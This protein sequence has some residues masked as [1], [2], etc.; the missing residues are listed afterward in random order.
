MNPDGMVALLNYRVS[1]INT[2][3]ERSLNDVCTC[4][5]MVL[6]VSLPNLHGL[7]NLTTILAYFTFWKDGLKVIKL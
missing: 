2:P 7:L 4:R 5:R 1:F 3:C 6:L